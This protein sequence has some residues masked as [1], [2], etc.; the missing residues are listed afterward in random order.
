MDKDSIFLWPCQAKF[1]PCLSFVFPQSKLK[2]CVVSKSLKC[3]ES[4][5]ERIV[6]GTKAPG[7]RQG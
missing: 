2:E 6:P 7:C 1:A 4:G 3:V 5:G